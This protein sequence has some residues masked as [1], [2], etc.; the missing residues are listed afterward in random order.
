MGANR[1]KDEQRSRWG[2][3]IPVIQ[4]IINGA[5]VIIRQLIGQGHHPF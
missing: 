2:E 4:T 5:I 1:K 3:W